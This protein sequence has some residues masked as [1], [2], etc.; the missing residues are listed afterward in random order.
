VPKPEQRVTVKLEQ[1]E[2]NTQ[3]TIDKTT[4]NAAAEII[5]RLDSQLVGSLAPK[6]VA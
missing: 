6:P 4:V 2:D 3:K 5:K 1:K